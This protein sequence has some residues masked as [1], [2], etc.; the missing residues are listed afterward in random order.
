MKSEIASSEL[1]IVLCNKRN[2]KN[3]CVVVAVLHITY[4]F[5]SNN[6][7]V[8]NKGG[9]RV[10]SSEAIKNTNFIIVFMQ[11]RSFSRAYLISFGNEQSLHIALVCLSSLSWFRID[12]KDQHSNSFPPLQ[13]TTKGKPVSRFA[14]HFRLRVC[15][16][17]PDTIDMWSRDRLDLCALWLLRR[18]LRPGRWASPMVS[19]SR[20][21][22]DG[23]L[24]AEWRCESAYIIETNV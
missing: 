19:C 21:W 15:V 23:N 4:L 13:I 11:P 5:Q 8:T 6:N 14:V 18:W 2:K 24:L 3:A 17:L 22:T 7:G 20:A 10:V 1:V 16:H 12:T 9:K